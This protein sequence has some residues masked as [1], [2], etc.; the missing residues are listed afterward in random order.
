VDTLA[1]YES[2]H[3][4]ALCPIQREAIRSFNG[5]HVLTAPTT[6]AETREFKKSMDAQ[7]Q[8]VV[9]IMTLFLTQAVTGGA[10][11]MTPAAVFPQART[12]AQSAAHNLPR[13]SAVPFSSNRSQPPA[14]PLPPVS[15]QTEPHHAAQASQAMPIPGLRIP[16]LPQGKDAW[17]MAVAQWEEIDPSTGKSL[18]DWPT[19]WYTGTMRP[20]YA[21]KRTA[22]QIIADEYNRLVTR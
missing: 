12:P 20:V 10:A 16:N 22:R 19:E 3:S 11:N 15:R 8:S 21:A 1:S 9:A 4:D 5:D 6:A 17:R 7:F 18:K 14:I 13:P 2:N